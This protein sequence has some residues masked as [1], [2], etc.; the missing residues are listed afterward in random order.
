MPDTVVTPQSQDTSLG[1]VMFRRIVANT[2]TPAL[3]EPK[4]LPKE[5]RY[6]RHV[7][8]NRRYGNQWDIDEE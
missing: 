6:Q 7:R 5:E 3:E 2:K 8:E 4:D 1:L